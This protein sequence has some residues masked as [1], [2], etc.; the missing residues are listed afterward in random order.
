MPDTVYVG[1]GDAIFINGPEGFQTYLW[2]PSNQINNQFSQGVTFIGTQSQTLVVE[3]THSDGCVITDSFVVIVVELTIPNG[4]SPNS[5]G[6]NDVFRIPQLDDYP[7]SFSVWNRWGD[8]VLD[9][10][11]YQNTWDGTC[12]TATCIGSGDLPE[13]TYFYLVDVEG[14]TFSGYITLKR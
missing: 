6:K 2:T 12:Q 13:G 7:G 14:I 5:D 3:A 10:P 4:F 9:D 11:N 1:A 8:L